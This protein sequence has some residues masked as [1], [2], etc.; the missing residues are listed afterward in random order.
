MEGGIAETLLWSVVGEAGH[1]KGGSEGNAEG[2]MKNPRK[3]H[4]CD[5]VKGMQKGECRMKNSVRLHQGYIKATSKR[6][7]GVLIAT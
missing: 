5:I 6:L 4:P 1:A 2:R 7:Q 3:L